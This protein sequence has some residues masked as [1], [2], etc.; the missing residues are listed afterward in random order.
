MNQVFR[1]RTGCCAALAGV[2]ASLHCD[3]LRCVTASVTEADLLYL[4]LRHFGESTTLIGMSRLSIALLGAPLI[5]VDDQP[6]EVDTRKAIALLAY[7]AVT[8]RRHQRDSLAALLWPELEQSKARAALRRTLSA[9]NRTP[10]SAWLDADRESIALRRNDDLWCDVWAFRTIAAQETADLDP[11]QL[12]QAVELYRDDFL[13]GFSLRDSFNFDDWQFFEAQELR[14]TFCA[15]LDRLVERL[16]RAQAFAQAIIYARRRL[17][18]DPLHE[19]AYRTLM[20]LYVWSGQR[21]AALRQYRTCIATLEEELGVP[22]LAETVALYEQIVNEEPIPQPDADPQPQTAFLPDSADARLN[23][24]PGAEPYPLVGRA[25]ALQAL[26]DSYQAAAGNSSV[27]ILEGE[28]GIGKTRLLSAFVE[29]SSAHGATVLRTEC[30]AGEQEIAYAPIIAL[31]RAGLHLPD[32]ETRLAQMPEHARFEAARLLPELDPVHHAS[33]PMTLDATAASGR[34]FEGV[35]VAL[36]TLLGESPPG[37]LAVDNVHWADRAT[38]DFLGYFLRRRH[39]IPICVIL[40]L[41]SEHLRPADRLQQLLADLS[42]ETTRTL[43]ELTRLTREETAELAEAGQHLFGADRDEVVER[44]WR[45]SEGLPLFLIEYLDLLARQP[46]LAA[47]DAWSLPGGVQELLQSRMQPVGEAGRQ[48]LTTAAV[49]GRSFHYDMLQAASGRSEEECVAGLEE[50]LAHR[51]VREA[52][53]LIYDFFHD[54]LRALVYGEMS[55][56]RRR[57]LHRRVAESLVRLERRLGMSGEEVPAMLAY[58]YS[59]AGLEAAAMEAHVQAAQNAAR[60]YANQAAI[61]H[62][63]QALALGYDQVTA[64]R[65]QLGDLHMLLGEYEIARNNYEAAAARANG[66]DLRLLEHKLGRVYHRLGQWKLADYHYGQALAGDDQSIDPVYS[67]QILADRSLVAHRQG[68]DETAR[69]HAEAARRAAADDPAALARVYGLLSILARSAGDPDGALTYAR[70]SKAMAERYGAD[71][72]LIIAAGNSLALAC[73]QNGALNEAIEEAQAALSICRRIGDRH[74]EAA[75]H[76]NLA[77]F[78]HAL[79]QEEA[80]MAHLKQ[81]VTLFAAIGAAAAAEERARQ[82]EIWMLSEW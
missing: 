21:N 68:Q 3:R 7:L 34:F 14:D 63:E 54:Q 51:L 76:N 24:P 36:E 44:L 29:A 75:L 28:A 50:L 43:I 70:E 31:L 19:P 61:H 41:R 23:E 2:A 22:P 53:G 27:L 74:H 56:A 10:A 16:V 59:A 65:A 8:D 45:A 1:R 79:G 25:R 37:I 6:V 82:P 35:T 73:A 60:V 17:Q 71:P 11:A 20:R 15:L 77:D 47:A 55:A 40:T 48:L 78:Y 39:G 64:A 81:A 69:M 67:A 52:D 66:D 46:D 49:I 9:L 33:A 62:W 4:S 57:L 80:A 72:A 12:I 42:P 38:L 18:L 13:A 58:H 26:A 32:T 5:G 30:Y